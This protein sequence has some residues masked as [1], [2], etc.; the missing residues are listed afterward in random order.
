MYDA[1]IIGGG[2]G[3]LTVAIELARKG[4]SVIVIEKHTYPFHKV[5]GEYISNE[6]RSYVEHIGLDLNRLG[7]SNID[8]FQLTSITG[9]S[10]HSPL[11]MGGFGISRFTL[12]FELYKIALGLGVSFE[13]NASVED[14]QRI[15]EAFFVDTNTNKTFHAKILIGSY[16]KRAKVDKI[17]KRP[18]PKQQ[19]SYLGVK[20]HIS[21]DYPKDLISLHN[22][23]GGYCGI[24]AIENN[25]YCLCYLTA[26]ANLKNKSNIKQM[27]EEV[28]YKNPFLKEIFIKADF[29]FTKPEV[30]NEV[31]FVSKSQ[32]HENVIMV[33]DSAGLITPLAGN[34]MSIAI[35][36]GF[37]AAQLIQDFLLGNL[38]RTELEKLYITIWNTNF[39]NQLW[40]GRQLQRL[41]GKEK[42]SEFAINFLK[43]IPVLMPF[44]IRSTH[45][46]VLEF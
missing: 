44:V 13:L 31:V 37:F 20:Y 23:E 14:T 21:I 18:I 11:E 36:S 19:T 34:G 7:A 8:K 39:K 17:I 16:G 45:G 1:I 29:L 24:S 26:T 12:D 38:T 42:T 27:E 41:F 22:F 30:I 3:G 28:L 15:N 40:R 5:C 4:F 35:R 10:L 6:V 9:K 33:G 43:R 32:V 2:L 46:K 25:K